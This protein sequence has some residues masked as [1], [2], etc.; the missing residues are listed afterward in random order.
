MKVMSEEAWAKKRQY[1]KQ[2]GELAAQK[3]LVPNMIMFMGI[4]VVVVV[5]IFS[6]MFS[7]LKS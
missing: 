7:S 2:R 3:L 4:L 6:S 1:A 5:P